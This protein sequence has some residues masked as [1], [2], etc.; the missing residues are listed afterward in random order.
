MKHLYKINGKTYNSLDE[1]PE[2]MRKLLDADGN[3]IPDMIEDN[4]EMFKS[5]DGKQIA[6][7]AK[8]TEHK[9]IDE[10]SDEYKDTM[11][12]YKTKM[13]IAVVA[14]ALIFLYAYLT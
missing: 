9:L 6:F 5:P 11:R 4:P 10:N 7:A 14:I 13:L 1:I 8:K 2:D 3:G 12:Q